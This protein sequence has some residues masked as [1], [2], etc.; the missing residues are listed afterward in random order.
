MKPFCVTFLALA[1]SVI[2]VAAHSQEKPLVVITRFD[3]SPPG[4]DKDSLAKRLPDEIADRLKR[5]G[6]VTPSVITPSDIELFR[7]VAGQAMAKAR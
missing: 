7:D 4:T 3:V 5:L 6:K 2:A 1:I